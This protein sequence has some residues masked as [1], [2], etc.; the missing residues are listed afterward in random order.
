METLQYST[1]DVTRGCNPD[2]VLFV[3]NM[4][5]EPKKYGGQYGNSVER[6]LFTRTSVKDIRKSFENVAVQEC[7]DDSSKDKETKK[8]RNPFEI[9]EKGQ[10][11][12]KEKEDSSRKR[13][14]R[15]EEFIKDHESKTPVKKKQCS[16][17]VYNTIKKFALSDDQESEGVKRKVM[18]SLESHQMLID[19]INSRIKNYCAFVDQVSD[20]A[21][22]TFS[23]GLVLAALAHSFNPFKSSFFNIAKKGRD[24][25]LKFAWQAFRDI[26]GEEPVYSL[27][28]V[29]S[30]PSKGLDRKCLLAMLFL[31]REKIILQNY[32]TRYQSIRKY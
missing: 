8:Y 4:I 1:N 7:E 17:T 5:C 16:G 14:L 26:T 27:Q 11:D 32:N 3:R 18:T 13:K 21:V 19:W 23:N 2:R 31:I 24:D 20:L 12:S 15:I 6:K 10:N 25:K 29:L 28:D 30:A 9:V 22:S